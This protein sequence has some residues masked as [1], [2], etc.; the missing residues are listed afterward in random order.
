MATKQTEKGNVVSVA[1]GKFQLIVANIETTDNSIKFTPYIKVTNKLDKAHTATIKWTTASGKK[2]KLTKKS[3]KGAGNHFSTSKTYSNGDYEVKIV[4][5]IAG[6]KSTVVVTGTKKPKQPKLTV[7]NSGSFHFKIT[8]S[9]TGKK[10]IPTEQVILK[11][12][13]DNIDA[14]WE[15]LKTWNHTEYGAYSYTYHDQTVEPGHRYKYE[16]KAGNDNGDTSW[17]IKPG[18]NA[19]EWYYT[20]PPEDVPDV[21]HA[22]NSNKQNTI[23][24]RQKGDEVDKKLITEYVIR[25]SE[26][27][28][29]FKDIGSKKPVG[30][31]NITLTYEDTTTTVD[32]YYRYIVV[33][34]NARGLSTISH[35][36]D[37]GTDATYNTPAAPLKIRAEKQRDD[38]IKVILDNRTKTG[39]ILQ[40]AKYQDGVWTQFEDIPEG[41]APVT[42]YIDESSTTGT[43]VKY[44]A[45]NGNDDLPE[46]DEF[47]PWIESEE[48]ETL[49]PPNAPT[50][51]RP[52]NGTAITTDH[53]TLRFEWIHNPTDGTAQT[54][55]QLVV[56]RN[57][58]STSTYTVGAEP[59]RDVTISNY[60]PLDVITW[61]VRTK[62][63]HADWSD[64]SEENTFTVYDLPEIHITSPQNGST[65]EN[66]PIQLNYTYSDLSGVLESLKLDIFDSEDEIVHSEDLPV[67]AGTSGSYTYSLSGYLFDN[68]KNYTLKLTALSDIGLQAVDQIGIYIEYVPVKLSNE[69][70]VDLDPDPETGY[71]SLHI[72]SAPILPDP[73]PDPEEPAPIIVNSPVVRALLYRVYDNKRTL[74][75]EVSEDEQLI[76]KFAP[77]NC[78]FEYELLEVAENG[79][80]SIVSEECEIDSDYW[81]LYYGNNYDK[82]AKAFWDPNGDVTLT[83]PEKQQIRYS[84]REYPVT[85]DSKGNEETYS[86]SFTITDRDELNHFREMMKE[87]GQGFW[88]SADGFVYRADFD[89][90]FSADYTT[91]E[92]RWSAKIEVTRIE[93]DL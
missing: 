16:V 43:V 62:G 36:T 37:E 48:L 33:P 64:Y 86:L 8:V 91:E 89:F 65:I 24:W 79:N 92:I 80:I 6:K 84:G 67:G 61:K 63:Q 55:A 44:R 82:I 66:L 52:V 10:A 12:R 17:Q 18:S 78:V 27:G 40:I 21:M 58:S 26:S 93:G 71:V 22:R 47:S 31:E 39:N 25:R 53:A 19:N 49:T 28:A 15:E 77:L 13:T 88:K 14:N 32:N 11:R 87:G 46:A 70:L 38:T 41:E 5:S 20:L 42:E 90:S 73:D 56:K 3:V 81:Y 30:I 57:G 29:A 1:G 9:G 54:E 60:N 2:R 7:E 59:Y 50:L 4:A 74:V 68:E 75:K 51:V 85:Y 69:Y 83:R 72:T 34:K 23:S 45:R 76:D 35:P